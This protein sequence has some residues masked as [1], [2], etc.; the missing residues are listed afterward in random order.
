MYQAWPVDDVAIFKQR[1]LHRLKELA[2]ESGRSQFVMP[3][4]L[5]LVIDRTNGGDV[6]AQEL[7]DRFRLVDMESRNLIDFYFL[8]WR[9]TADES[10][11]G[12]GHPEAGKQGDATE[13]A[14]RFDLKSFEKFRTALKDAGVGQ[15]GGNAD[16]ILVDAHYAPDDIS[17][18]FQEAI[19]VDL[20]LSRAEDDFPTLGSF[21]QAVIEAAEQVRHDAVLLQ[22]GGLVFAISD[23]LGLA[24]AKKSLLDAFLEKFGKILGA[25]KLAAVAVRRIGPVV[26]L[27]Q[28]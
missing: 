23:K 28:L 27:R 4:G 20:S 19:R 9:R 6:T 7:V 3:V 2:E 17:L 8:G 21:L 18:D 25:K 14:I 12:A 11:R 5:V 16:L 10:D 13:P 1:L 22:D 26:P 15:F 24:I